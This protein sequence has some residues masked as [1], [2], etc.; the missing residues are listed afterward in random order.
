MCAYVCVGGTEE[1]E[2][3]GGGKEEEEWKKRMTHRKENYLR[4][5]YLCANARGSAG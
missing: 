3:C 5:Y 1:E 4:L 2:M